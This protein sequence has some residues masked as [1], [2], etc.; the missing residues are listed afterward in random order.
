M[1][2]QEGAISDAVARFLKSHGEMGE[3]GK[4]RGGLAYG[5]WRKYRSSLWLLVS[6]CDEQRITE[7]PDW[8]TAVDRPSP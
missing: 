6:F 7:L 3:D 1:A 8:L 4:Y 5:S 2:V